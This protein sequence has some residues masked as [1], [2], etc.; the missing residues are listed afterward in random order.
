MTGGKELLAKIYDSLGMNVVSFPYGPMPSQP[1]GW[2][3]KPITKADDFKAKAAQLGKEAETALA[4]L[5]AD[6]AGV[7]AAIGP[8][9]KSCASCHENYRVKK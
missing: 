5:P 4:S 9:G 1:L 8:I 7:A 2:Y 3:K 6:Q